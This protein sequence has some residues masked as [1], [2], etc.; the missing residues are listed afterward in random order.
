MD[1]MPVAPSPSSSAPNEGGGKGK[2]A[3]PS[4][5]RPQRS[6]SHSSSGKGYTA[7]AVDT[8]DESGH[9]GVPQS[10]SLLGG[11]ASSLV[12]AVSQIRDSFQESIRDVPPPQVRRVLVS[13]GVVVLLICPLHQ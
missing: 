7:R 13:K 5:P 11:S 2:G 6:S 9:C 8:S 3:A 12:R 4:V 10:P 1:A